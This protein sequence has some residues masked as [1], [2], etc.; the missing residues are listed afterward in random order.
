MAKKSKKEESAPF[1]APEPIIDPHTYE[2]LKSV[3]VSAENF[4]N[5]SAKVVN[6]SGKSIVVI[7]KNE[8]GKSSLIQVLKGTLNSRNLPEIG[9]KE[10]TEEGRIIH[11]IAG[12]VDG[13]Y[14]EYTIEYHFSEKHKSGR[15]KVYDQNMNEVTSPAT[16]LK[17]VI[18]QVSFSPVKFLNEKK[19]KKLQII[20]QLTGRGKDI[21]VINYDIEVK[22]K[23]ISARKNVVESIEAELSAVTY[24]DDQKRLYGIQVPLDPIN[25]KITDLADVNKQF[26]DIQRQRDGFNNDAVNCQ[27]LIHQKINETTSKYAEI[28]RLQKEIEKLNLD[29]QNLDIQKKGS[30]QNVEIADKWMLANPA[31]DMATIADELRIATEHNGHHAKIVE[32]SDKH[33]KLYA[34]KQEIVAIEKQI[35]DLIT[36]RTEII[37]SSQLPVKGLSF[38]DSEIFLNGLPFEEGQI[39]T[40]TLWD[41][42]IDIAL[43]IN[44][45][46]KGVFIDDGS[47]FDKDHLIATIKKIEEK[48]GF[49]IVEMVNWEG[50][51]LDV[52]FTEELLK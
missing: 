38:T 42:C 46:Y 52:K 7:G 9:L 32:L 2:G 34:D 35:S 6:I 16:I 13:E 5:I 36:K 28:D 31:P 48:G 39:N 47:L 27:N 17:N 45:N 51:E 10:G 30:E 23:D 44:S 41:V 20:K 50:G 19:E 18:G 12:R 8:G 3:F 49:A 21:D 1:T 40:Q 15:I 43:A 26:N 25:K 11:R 33:K 24:T 37:E 14:L 29:I 22:K 4:K